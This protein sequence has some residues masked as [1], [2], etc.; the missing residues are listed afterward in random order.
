MLYLCHKAETSATV[1]SGT[2]AKQDKDK[3]KIMKTI[4]ID[5]FKSIIENANWIRT[6]E[7]EILD[8]IT[9]KDYDYDSESEEYEVIE[10]EHE[11]GIAFKESSFEDITIK[12]T[13]MFNYDLN[14]IDTF[15]NSPDSSTEWIVEGISVV[16]E[17]GDELDSDEIGN[18]LNDDF[19]TI[20]YSEL[21]IEQ[22]IEI[23]VSDDGEKDD[24]DTFIINVDN[25]PSIEFK[26]ELLATTRSNENSSYGSNFSGT[27]GK[28]AK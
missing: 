20:D 26:G 19:R 28:W 9:R 11:Y 15:E 23:D 21:E 13:E 8:K 22:K 5:Q 16:D 25:A 10:I 14:E 6:E 1:A 3:D 18:Y 2:L 7:I 12:Y 4:S 24:M 27:A 17:D